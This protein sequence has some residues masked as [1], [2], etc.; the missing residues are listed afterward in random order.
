MIRAK[1]DKFHGKN[2]DFVDS[3]FVKTFDELFLQDSENESI[4]NGD[5]TKDSSIEEDSD[6]DLESDLVSMSM[7]AETDHEK[8]S[9]SKHLF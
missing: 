6:P 2:L 7:V 8:H 1:N 9:G 3:G 4:D 5:T